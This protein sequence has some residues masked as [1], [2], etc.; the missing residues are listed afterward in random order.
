MKN[1][2]RS[3]ASPDRVDH[4]VRRLLAAMLLIALTFP[5]PRT[6]AADA[7]LTV[8]QDDFEG[9]L[10]PVTHSAPERDI[11]GLGW[12][13]PGSGH[14]LTVTPDG[15]LK[16][17]ADAAC[18]SVQVPRQ[19]GQATITVEFMYKSPPRNPAWLG[20]GFT[21]GVHD[22]LNA[23]SGPWLQLTGD[24]R[25]RLFAGEG[26]ANLFA[27]R[28][29]SYE[30]GAVPVKMQ[31]NVERNTV[32]IWFAE[33]QVISADLA[34]FVCDQ[35]SL[36]YLTVQSSGSTETAGHLIDDLRVSMIPRREPLRA[37]PVD[38]IVRVPAPGGG[39][40]APAIQRAFDD[41]MNS[42]ALKDKVVEIRFA[43]G[44][45]RIGDPA[46]FEGDVLHLK[47]RDNVYINGN[48]ATLILRN[49]TQSMLL[50]D[51]CSNII[52]ENF[53]VTCY[54]YPFVQGVITAKDD[55]KMQ[56]D[57]AL[58]ANSLNPLDEVY[59]FGGKTFFNNPAA[60]EWGYPIQDPAG[61]WEKPDHGDYGRI[62]NGRMPHYRHRSIESLGGN[63]I[64]IRL[65][66]DTDTLQVG[67]HYVALA[68]WKRCIRGIHT[69]NITVSGIKADM[70]PGQF[71]AG[72][73]NDLWN[74][75]NCEIT[76]RRGLWNSL[77]GDFV[78]TE[79][80]TG[81]WMEGNKVWG[82]SDDVIN[83]V[84]KG[85][86]VTAQP[87]PN[88]LRLV[89][90]KGNGSTAGVP[91]SAFRAG[92]AIRFINGATGE[93][94]DEAVVVDYGKARVDRSLVDTITL[95]KAIADVVLFNGND[96]SGTCVNNLALY[97]GFVIRDNV[98]R[99]NR[100]AVRI[101]RNGQV[102]GNR[103]QGHSRNPIRML[104]T[105]AR[106][107]F[108]SPGDGG[109]VIFD[110][111]FKDYA[112]TEPAP[113]ITA[114]EPGIETVYS[115][116]APGNNQGTPVDRI[117]VYSDLYIHRNTWSDWRDHAIFL[118]NTANARV[119]GNV[120]Q[121]PATDETPISTIEIRSGRDIDIVDND[122]SAVPGDIDHVNADRHSSDISVEP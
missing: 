33:E 20:V 2:A 112:F 99:H 69:H 40:D 61:E 64:R 38:A 58:D 13:T 32:R 71:F 7:A 60:Q 18:A 74:I 49:L 82:G 118:G 4:T 116:H 109:V 16:A 65:K 80:R 28:R 70:F 108:F 37:L 86:V 87:A 114:D 106:A 111:V 19:G 1:F 5:L 105:T 78:L 103:L 107:K 8:F 59:R 83:Q 11:V 48:G 93:V 88:Q 75:L 101:G 81:I 6:Q 55:A 51:S 104:G 96:A 53:N 98:F 12:Q 15:W 29:V 76:M 97:S 117:Q 42:A 110:N 14:G 30:G 9:G 24:G 119:T 3:F 62:K 89:K 10:R 77:N 52:V 79:T 100:G 25:L 72:S 56:I 47:D 45:Y 31:F 102:Y 85:F 95:N 115:R 54:P 90:Y 46:A 68:R 73:N 22:L 121:A 36:R 39:D 57:L 27:S 26:D 94:F 113:L 91:S 44:E 67:D 43:P 92:D 35:S 84:T 23:K 120:F 34:A 66:T 17:D 63:R 21:A 122:F 41:V 50:L